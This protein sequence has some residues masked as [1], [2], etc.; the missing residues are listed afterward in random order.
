MK[1]KFKQWRSTEPTI[2]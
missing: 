2:L 1:R